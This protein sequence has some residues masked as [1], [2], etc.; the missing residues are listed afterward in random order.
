M[1]DHDY[2][3]TLEVFI[4]RSA[5]RKEPAVVIA[6]GEAEKVLS[7]ITDAVELDLDFDV[8]DKATKTKSYRPVSEEEF[9]EMRWKAAAAVEKL[10]AVLKNN[11][12]LELE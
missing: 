5:K 3:N 12:P 9:N 1:D 4:K 6:R 2:M 10:N 7:E 8:H 11:D